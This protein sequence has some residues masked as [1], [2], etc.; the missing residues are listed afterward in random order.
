M[1]KGLPILVVLGLILL[2]GAVIGAILYTGDFQQTFIGDPSLCNGQV[3]SVSPQI[4]KTFSNDLGKEVIRVTYSTLPSSECVNIIIEESDFENQLDNF[5]AEGDILLDISLK[6]QKKIFNIQ[7]QSNQNFKK[8]SS[9]NIGNQNLCTQS[10]CQE[11]GVNNVYASLFRYST[12]SDCFCYFDDLKGIGGDFQLT[13]GIEW[14]TDVRIGNAPTLTLDNSRL[15][16]SVGSRAFIKWSGNL[17]S[18]TQFSGLVGQKDTYSPNSDNRWRMISQGTYSTLETTYQGIK[19]DFISCDTSGFAGHG[20]CPNVVSRGVGYN[21]DFD[22]RTQDQTNQWSIDEPAVE[23]G[24]ASINGNQLTANLQSPIVYPT[25]VVDLAV[26]EVGIFVQSGGRPDVTCPSNF[27]ITSGETENVNIGIRNT[28]S[29]SGSYDFQ[30]SCSKG[31]Q[32]L[33]PS[34]PLNIGAG[35]SKNIQVQA[36]LVTESTDTASCTFTAR[37][38]NTLQEDS[39]GFSYQAEKRNECVTGTKICEAGN[40]ELWTC[41]SDGT[42]NKESCNSGCGLLNGEIACLDGSSGVGSAETRQQCEEKAGRNPLAGWTWVESE[43]SSCGINPLCHLGITEPKV[44][45]TA[46][47]EA[48]FLIY[49]IAGLIGAVILVLV[50]IVGILAYR[51]ISQ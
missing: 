42:Y 33:S 13:E 9:I 8:I 45:T 39:C 19:N 36:G 1:A 7:S 23:N 41:Q 35:Q 14:K 18:N 29:G 16:G 15:S 34:P 28:G 43:T 2:G 44:I 6:E 40:T 26:E 17:A 11:N 27:D 46:K 32:F 48:S 31:S 49:W 24:G 20:N 21:G 50:I 30:I 51:R 37:E 22:Q 5:N 3:L 12:G 47:C 25:F 4:Q 10:R 38:V